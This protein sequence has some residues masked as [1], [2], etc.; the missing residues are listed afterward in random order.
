MALTY[1]YVDRRKE[2]SDFPQDRDFN[3]AEVSFRQCR[4]GDA[5]VWWQQHTMI[6]AING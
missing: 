1:V 3:Y 4:L 2:K 5:P 6:R